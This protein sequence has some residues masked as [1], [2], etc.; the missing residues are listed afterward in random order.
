MW[1]YFISFVISWF[2]VLVYIEFDKDNWTYTDMTEYDE[3]AMVHLVGFL[4]AMIL[5][6]C[7]PLLLLGFV[8]AKLSQYIKSKIVSFKNRKDKEDEIHPGD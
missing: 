2:A 7:W 4:F 6:F 5:P 3:F 1:Y 8:L